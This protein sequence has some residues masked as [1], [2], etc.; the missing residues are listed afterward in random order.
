MQTGP[1]AWK[2][3]W[4]IELIETTSPDWRDLFDL[5]V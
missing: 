5:T 4:K 2:R 1:K 3:L